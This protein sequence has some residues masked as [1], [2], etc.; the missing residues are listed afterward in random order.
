MHET[1]GQVQFVVF[2][3]FKSAYLHQIIRTGNHVITYLSFKWKKHHDSQDRIFTTCYTICNI[4]PLHVCTH[5]TWKMDSF[6][7]SFFRVFHCFNHL[8]AGWW[9]KQYTLITSR[10]QKVQNSLWQQSIISEPSDPK[11]WPKRNFIISI[12]SQIKM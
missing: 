1:V 11:D 8:L 3:K 10:N 12:H 7:A 4:H 9:I 2:E 5:A 6:S